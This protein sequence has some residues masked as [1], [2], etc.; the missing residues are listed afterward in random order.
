MFRECGRETE[1]FKRVEIAIGK[2]QANYIEQGVGSPHQNSDG[3]TV[4]TNSRVQ[5]PLNKGYTS[6]RGAVSVESGNG[7]SSVAVELK[8]DGRSVWN[9]VIAGDT[10]GA[11]TFSVSVVDGAVLTVESKS[12]RAVDGPMLVRWRWTELHSH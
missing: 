8:V 2:L 10:L 9:G 3:F 11:A 1:N 12:Q 4:I 6:I 5:F 7:H